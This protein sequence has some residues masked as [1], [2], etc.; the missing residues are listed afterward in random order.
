MNIDELELKHVAQ[1][2]DLILFM[3]KMTLIKDTSSKLQSQ[4][5]IGEIYY[6]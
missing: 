5:K 4:N 1:Y 3:K 2:Q 6:E